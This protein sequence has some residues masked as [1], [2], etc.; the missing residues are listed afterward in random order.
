M[1]GA[2]AAGASMRA[3]SSEASSEVR[4]QTDDDT[5]DLEWLPST[6]SEAHVAVLSGYQADVG[7]N[8]SGCAHV[9]PG[10]DEYTLLIDLVL[11]DIQCVTQAHIHEGGRD[12][13]GPIVAPLLEY[14]E[15]LD[16]S[17]DGDPLT[18]TPDMP[19]IEGVAIDDPDLVESILDD[20]S[21]YYINVHTAHNPEGEIRGQIRGFD[22]GQETDIEPV[23]AEFTV[24]SL[25]PDD[26][27]VVRGDQ[28]DVSARIRNIGDVTDTQTVE[29]RIDGE[30]VAEREL[31]LGCRRSRTVRFEDV[32]TEDLEPDEYEHGIFT[33]DDSETGSLRILR[34]A[35]FRVSDLDPVDVTVTRGELID[36]SATIEN[37]GEVSDR[38]TIEFRIDG[39]IVDDQRLELDGEESETVTFEDI[40]TESLEPDEYEHGIFTED[41]SETGTLT[42]E[43]IEDIYSIDSCRI[44]DEPGEYEVV[45]DIEEPAQEYEGLA[46]PA[47]LWIQSSDVIIEGNDHTIT[48]EGEGVGIK[49]GAPQE[50]GEAAPIDDIEIR[51]LRTENWRAGFEIGDDNEWETQALLESITATDNGIGVSLP[52]ANGSELVDVTSSRNETGVYFWETSEVTLAEVTVSENDRHGLY[53]SDSAWDCEFTDVTATDNG[54]HGITVQQDSGGNLFSNCYIATNEEG[55]ITAGDSGVTTVEETTVENNGGI[56]ISARGASFDL[57]TVVIRENQ[58]WQL[59][60]ETSEAQFTATEL[61]IGDSAE[62]AFSDESLS[63]DAINRDELP[64]LS[65]DLVAVGDGV[66][67]LDADEA[68]AILRYDEDEVDGD[69]VGLWRYD[70]DEWSL[71]DSFDADGTIEA[72]LTEDGIYAPIEDTEE[73][74]IYSIDS[75]TVINEPGEYEIVADIDEGA[76]EYDG[77]HQ[78]A[79]IW[80]RSS[81]VVLEGNGHTISGDGDGVGIFV[82]D[83]DHSTREDPL[84]DVMIR[85]LRVTEYELG[86]SLGSD[87]GGW[88]ESILEDVAVDDNTGIGVYLFAA[89]GSELRNVTADRNGSHGIQ[90]WETDNHVFENVTVSE[91]SDFGIFFWDLVRDSEFTDITVTENGSGGIRTGVDVSS[92]TFSNLTIAGN[93]GTGYY[94]HEGGTDTIR[95]S[96]I[97]DN[98]GS[99][100]LLGSNSLEVQT[101]TI[102]DNSDWQVESDDNDARLTVRELEIGDSAQF[103]FDDEGLSLDAVDVD[104]LPDLPGDVFAVGDGVEIIDVDEVDATLTYDE[105]NVEGDEVGLWRY[106]GDEWILV[107]SF[108]ADGTIEAEL[109]ED[110]I[111]APVEDQSEEEVENGDEDDEEEADEDVD[112]GE[113][114]ENGD[115]DVVNG[116]DDEDEDTDD[117]D[118]DDLDDDDDEDDENGNNDSDSEGDSMTENDA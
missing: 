99:G 62:F 116:V 73:S 89:D 39:D 96:I 1:M 109:T 26:A 91:N 3:L 100:L 28:I 82:G 81:D 112:N 74:D 32:D 19:L 102:R 63:L 67:I 71:V 90:L 42:I 20:P 110:G 86:I 78:P 31:E 38:Q 35:E 68:D 41:D 9:L 48:G 84:E 50:D 10:V 16:G 98:D 53:L 85:D 72:E 58:D 94:A 104:D 13:T 21:Q 17:G 76:R 57:E 92:N 105:D 11:E 29:L 7:T 14:T 117:D 80:V 37:V 66:E 118:E 43:P 95:E 56:G 55:G 114:E 30:V 6:A 18:T 22:L 33:E 107:D 79:C 101:V 88:V 108:D 49:A 75:C 65:D 64:E 60:S 70:D 45:A 15:E 93:G 113:E 5:P 24:S 36:V 106:D 61:D 97:E 111:Y 23:P 59:E 83:P 46:E 51:N 27:T 87:Q 69:D 54:R 4:T 40:D 52:W 44:I 77:L 34:P 115:D 8:A 25:D 2:L 103:E 12:E 47:C